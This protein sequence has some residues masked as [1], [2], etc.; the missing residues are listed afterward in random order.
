MTDNRRS[1]KI[2]T[3]SLSLP[4][5]LARLPEESF[6]TPGMRERLQAG[7]RTNQIRL[8]EEF[9]LF[10]PETRLAFFVPPWQWEEGVED[11][12][13][14]RLWKR[15]WGELQGKVSEREKQASKTLGM[16]V[17][18]QGVSFPLVERVGTNSA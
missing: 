17:P 6:D 7:D 11:G 3:S 9:K 15:V 1:I 13:S 5:S 2:N 14:K 10:S 4:S 18:K 8:L 12:G 16:A